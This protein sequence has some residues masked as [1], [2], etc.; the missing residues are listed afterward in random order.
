MA[1]SEQSIALLADH[2]EA[3]S[4]TWVAEY[5]RNRQAVLN[6]RKITASG[7]LRDSMQ[8][9]LTK[10][11]QQ[12]VTNSLELAFE[13]HGRFIDMKRLNVPKGG[14]EYIN[15]L[16]DWI[17][18]KGLTDRF[19]QKFVQSR[20]LRKPPQDV[21]NRMAWGIAIKRGRGYKRRGFGYAKSKS[22]A[23][24]DLYNRVAAGIPDI[25]LDEITKGL[26]ANN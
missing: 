10:T 15:A 14:T 8:F 24:T 18:R 25:V 21:L 3:E 23:I 19:V 7:Q 12:A 2:I 20:G 9:A 13:E 5:V 17:V 1:L 4:R 6:K 11:L 16:S 22:A 26:A